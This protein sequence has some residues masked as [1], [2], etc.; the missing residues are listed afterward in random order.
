[1]FL[2][3]LLQRNP[4]LADYANNIQVHFHLAQL[5]HKI[6]TEDKQK[7]LENITTSWQLYNFFN[8]CCMGIP[9]L[10]EALQDQFDISKKMT[11]LLGE[12]IVELKSA[13]IVQGPAFL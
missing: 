6:I 8:Q 9:S 10:G 3:S 13:M 12:R 2:Y 1:M 4:E 5:Y 7:L 11:E